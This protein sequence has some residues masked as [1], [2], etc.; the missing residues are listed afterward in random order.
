[1]AVVGIGARLEHSTEEHIHVEDMEK[2]LGMIKEI[3]RLTAQ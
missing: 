1:M 2:A 3:L